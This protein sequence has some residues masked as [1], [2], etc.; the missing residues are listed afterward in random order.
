[1]SGSPGGGL[2]GVACRTRRP[3][4]RRGPRGAPS[5]PSPRPCAGHRRGQVA[6]VGLDRAGDVVAALLRVDAQVERGRG[7]EASSLRHS[8]RRSAALP[9]R[10]S[11]QAR[12]FWRAALSGSAA[13][14]ALKAFSAS[15]M[16]PL[17]Y[18][19]SPSRRLSAS[20]SAA[21][22]LACQGGL[23]GGRGEPLARLGHL[24]LAVE[25]IGLR[26]R[27]GVGRGP[28]GRGARAFFRSAV[29][30]PKCSSSAYTS[31]RVK[32]ASFARSGFLSSGL[33]QLHVLLRRRRQSPFSRLA[34]ARRSS[35]S[36]R[37]ACASSR[38]ALE[39]PS[40]SSR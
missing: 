25:H 23:L 22:H 6:A 3:S 30:S 12:L 27:A 16:L 32:E 36:G 11:T 8:A 31:A 20:V 14:A 13:S 1:M 24:L 37:L 10:Y 21:I 19:S 7:T 40:S 38:T 35:S 15:F 18:A 9:L 33:R 4:S 5:T 39:L 29:A 2:V 28:A 34:S 17:A 26:E